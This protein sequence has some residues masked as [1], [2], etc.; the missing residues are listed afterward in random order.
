[1]FETLILLLLSILE[2]WCCIEIYN[3]CFRKEEIK[4]EG[5]NLWQY[6][7]LD[8]YQSLLLVHCIFCY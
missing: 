1:M 4:E 3:L 8:T 2:H 5:R 6:E 7:N